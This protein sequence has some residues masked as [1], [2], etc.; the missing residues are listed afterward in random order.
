MEHGGSC[1]LTF[2]VDIFNDVPDDGK[3]E[4]REVVRFR[5]GDDSR[6]LDEVEEMVNRYSDVYRLSSVDF[7]FD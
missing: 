7:V 3:V 4:F 1:V 5:K 6:Y 2:R